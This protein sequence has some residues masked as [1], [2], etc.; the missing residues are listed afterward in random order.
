LNFKKFKF[1]FILIF[2][3]IIIILII[4]AIGTFWPKYEEE[5][6]GLGLLGKNKTAEGYYP[7][8][9]PNLEIGSNVDWYIYV[10]NHFGKS[11]DILIKIKLLNS[12]MELPD[13]KEGR[14]S[15]IMAFTEFPLSLSMDEQ[16]LIPLSWS[17]YE[18]D[19]Q[20]S[21]SVIKKL[22]INDEIVQLSPVSSLDSRFTMVLEI[23]VFDPISQEYYFGWEDGSRLSSASTY[24]HF[25][26]II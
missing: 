25:N 16:L 22:I 4:A 9:N 17:I 19:N 15:P 6:I 3:L 11:N 2:I 23:W 1:I 24:I 21:L 12:E 20:N 8:D 26:V 18:A 10:E 13:D 7:D 5:F 14:A